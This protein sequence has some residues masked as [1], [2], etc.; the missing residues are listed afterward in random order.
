MVLH[1]SSCRT[2]CRAL[3]RR[4]G[5]SAA[6]A[7]ISSVAGPTESLPRDLVVLELRRLRRAAG[8]DPVSPRAA[9][10]PS[11]A[12]TLNA[13]PGGRPHRD[14]V[15]E[16]LSGKPRSVTVYPPPV[17]GRARAVDAREGRSHPRPSVRRRPW[18]VAVAPSR[19]VR[20]DRGLRTT[21]LLK[22]RASAS[23]T[24]DAQLSNMSQPDQGIRM[25]S[26]SPVWPCA[27]GPS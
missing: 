13:R 7:T 4:L 1:G 9:G 25:L 26:Y 18:L 2:G 11:F 3:R 24:A 15:L 14:A 10:P 12:A 8:G 17:H 22:T 23:R 27:G 5:F 19:G 21:G 6:K 16:K 20:D